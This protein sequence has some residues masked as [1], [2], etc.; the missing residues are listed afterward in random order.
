[1][2]K[3]RQDIKEQDKEREEYKRLA[4]VKMCDDNENKAKERD[5]NYKQFF[6]VYDGN[7]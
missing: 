6:Q 1:M 7:L 2:I 5:Q 3:F 4:Y